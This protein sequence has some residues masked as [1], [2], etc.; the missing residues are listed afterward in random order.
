MRQLGDYFI[1]RNS[2]GQQVPCPSGFQVYNRTLTRLSFMGPDGAETEFVDQNSGGALQFANSLRGTNWVSRDGSG[3]TFVSTTPIYDFNGLDPYVSYPSGYLYFKNGLRYKIEEGEVTEIRDRNGNLT[4]LNHLYSS[5][6][7]YRTEIIDPLNRMT[8]YERNANGHM[9]ISFPGTT[10]ITRQIIVEYMPL[11]LSLRPN[12]AGCTNCQ[13]YPQTVQ[14]VNQLFPNMANVNVYNPTVISAVVLPDGRRYQLFYTPYKEIARVDL[15]TGGVIEYDWVGMPSWQSCGSGMPTTMST[16]GDFILACDPSTTTATNG[17]RP[18]QWEIKRGVTQRRVYK[19]ATT[20]ESTT[21]YGAGPSVAT[22]VSTTDAAGT[23][24]NLEQH[25]Y[26]GNLYHIPFFPTDEIPWVDGKEYRTDNLDANANVLRRTDYC[27]KQRTH[28]GAGDACW[29]FNT[30]AMQDPR[31]TC[32]TNSLLDNGANLVS[33]TETDYDPV[34]AYNQPTAVREFDY[35]VGAPGNLLRQTLTTYMVNSLYT[36]TPTHIRSLPT[37]VRVQNGAGITV[38]RNDFEY[39]NYA[40]NALHSP[41]VDCPLASGFDPYNYGVSFTRRGNVTCTTT[42]TNAAAGT[43]I[44]DTYQEYDILGNVVKAMDAGRLVNGVVTRATTLFTYNDN[45][46]VANGV[47]QYGGNLDN[48]PPP[49]LGYTYASYAFVTKI[50]NELGQKVYSQY[51]YYTGKPVDFEDPN[52]IKSTYLYED[53]LDRLT[54]GI[55]AY[56]TANSKALTS[57]TYNDALR[58]ITS[59]SDQTNYYV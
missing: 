30:E 48:T 52:G 12:R 14:Q 57:I 19:D 25:W 8:S 50:T 35:G 43:G 33:K 36:A 56:G 31:Q 24:L 3:T 39:D 42:Y 47:T 4:K 1:C 20:L 40:E 9:V 10:G 16:L 58:Q 18:H 55:R 44:V 13:T 49:E 26:Y 23:I 51:D 15:P 37:Q 7:W 2:N 22:V 59:V 41:L 21:S 5:G 38:A 11:S 28:S 53:P 34:P 17:S 6:A 54:K 27:W 46:G 29:G 32:V 45:F